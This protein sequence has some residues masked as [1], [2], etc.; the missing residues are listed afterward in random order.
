MKIAAPAFRKDGVFFFMSCRSLCRHH[1]TRLESLMLSE[2][3]QASWHRDFLAVFPEQVDVV[4]VDE[5]LAAIAG[6]ECEVL[7]LGRVE[8][9]NRL[10]PAFLLHVFPDER[11][12]NPVASRVFETDH[13]FVVVFDLARHDLQFDVA[14]RIVVRCGVI[15][16]DA[17]G[18]LDFFGDVVVCA[19]VVRPAEIRRL[20][21]DEVVADV[22]AERRIAVIDFGVHG[23]GVVAV[24][25]REPRNVV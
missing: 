8:L 22:A 2:S 20:L 9:R 16:N 10:A 24:D 3:A 15:E 4:E 11:V 13:E 5:S 21:D 14:L 23:G 19:G 7:D 18:L 25:D 17:D 6:A 12:A 1:H